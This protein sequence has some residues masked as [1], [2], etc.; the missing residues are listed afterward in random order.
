MGTRPDRTRH[1]SA[2]QGVLS[3]HEREDMVLSDTTF[4]FITGRIA[5]AYQ[6]ATEAAGPDGRVDIAGGADTVNQFLSAGSVD[7]TRA[8]VRA[9][10][11]ER[12]AHYLSRSSRLSRT[13]PR[14]S[15][16]RSVKTPRSG[17]SSRAHG[18]DNERIRSLEP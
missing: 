15:L 9:N 17:L 6:R 4:T 7:E 11:D 18:S 12:D 13:C 2:L 5:E 3:H 16:S 1:W 14:V 10:C 8:G